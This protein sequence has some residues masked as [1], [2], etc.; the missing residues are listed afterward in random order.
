M[1]QIQ[2]SVAQEAKRDLKISF[3]LGKIADERSIEVADEEIN[4]QVA[5]MAQ[6]YGQRPE[7]MRHQL[8]ADGTL[9]QVAMS[10]RDGKVVKQLLSDAAV[11]EAA[12]DPTAEDKAA[13]AKKTAKKA[14]KKAAKKAAA[15]PAAE[16]KAAPAKKTAKKAGKKAKAE[17]EAGQ[18]ETTE[19]DQ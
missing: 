17:K 15:E 10:I 7:R 4:A 9:E 2:A 5:Y 19:A 16:D 8:E 13:P 1:T 14:G 11:T 6:Q 12:A 18:D 3:I